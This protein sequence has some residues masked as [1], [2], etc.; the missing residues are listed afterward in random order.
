MA[1][2][3][4]LEYRKAGLPL[5]DIAKIQLVNCNGVDSAVQKHEVTDVS[6]I[7][8]AFLDEDEPCAVIHIFSS[9]ANYQRSLAAAHEG[10]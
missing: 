2:Q 5:R 9:D 1:A 4:F 3:P 10:A 8:L 7:G 6:R